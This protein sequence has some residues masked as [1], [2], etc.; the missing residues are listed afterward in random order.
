LSWL[1]SDITDPI[2]PLAIAAILVSKETGASIVSSAII[3]RMN[4]RRVALEARMP[5][6]C[7]VIFIIYL[8]IF[9]ILSGLIDEAGELYNPKCAYE[10][11][12]RR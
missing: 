1:K 3:E 6:L 8:F 4:R 2:G 11:T 5:E 7:M 12:S 10:A 9:E